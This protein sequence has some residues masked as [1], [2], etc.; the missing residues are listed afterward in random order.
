MYE[1]LAESL[2]STAIKWFPG[3]GSEYL[4]RLLDE[5]V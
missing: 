1:R 3:Q 2:A 5:C 4:E